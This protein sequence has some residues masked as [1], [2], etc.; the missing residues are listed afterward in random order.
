L[1]AIGATLLTVIFGAHLLELDRLLEVEA[2][3][4]LVG[5][6]GQAGPLLFIGVCVVALLLHL[7][8]A[9]LIAIGAMLFG[10]LHGFAYGWV[11]AVAGS[12][13]TFLVARHLA[14]ETVQS[15]LRGRLGRLR[16]VDSRFQTHGFQLVLLLRLVLF[17]APPLNW[18][19]GA[20]SVRLRDYVAGTALGVVPG[21]ALTVYLGGS[22]AQADSYR[23][24]L[25]V[26]HLLPGAL[27]LAL[28]VAAGIA[29]RRLLARPI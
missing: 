6:Y 23:D 1:A 5:R 2:M 7:P 18:A 10:P 19:M 11:A 22:I 9:V 13:L 15:S 4:E 8:E 12:T 20:T 21:I 29:G 3:R 25:T 16:D 17:L 26:A 24:L 28:M 14:R 27:L